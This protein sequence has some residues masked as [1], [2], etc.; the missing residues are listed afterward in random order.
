MITHVT[1]D[2][3]YT[4]LLPF[5]YSSG[6]VLRICP[7]SESLPDDYANFWAFRGTSGD[8]YTL[9]GNVAGQYYHQPC[10]TC[11]GMAYHTVDGVDVWTEE[12]VRPLATLHF[13]PAADRYPTI[14]KDSGGSVAVGN[15]RFA[16][17]IFY[18]FEV[19]DNDHQPYFSRADT[20]VGVSWTASQYGDRRADVSGAPFALAKNS[21]RV[22]ISAWFLALCSGSVTF[23]SR[24][25]RI[26][27][28]CRRA[29]S[30]G[31]GI[32]SS[33]CSQ[34]A[35][36][37]ESLRQGN[38]SYQLVQSSEEMWLQQDTP[39]GGDPYSQW[40][41]SLQSVDQPGLK[42]TLGNSSSVLLTS[43][44]FDLWLYNF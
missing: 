8:K 13:S 10:T 33:A 29:S 44:G 6:G 21:Y 9:L 5:E 14:S 43:Y 22:K 42:I 38:A 25:I 41:F 34:A 40:L 27:A 17:G 12:P 30:E 28:V 26:N 32:G 15:G 11:P 39:Y 3:K 2:F 24:P 37:T 23:D 19:T 1:S 18:P 7:C 31:G 35:R 36:F 4:R 16:N 20:D